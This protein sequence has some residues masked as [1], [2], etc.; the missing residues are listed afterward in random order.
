MVRQKPQAF[1][2]SYINRFMRAYS[3]MPLRFKTKIVSYQKSAEQLFQINKVNF[4]SMLL[5][6]ML[7]VIKMYRTMSK[8][9]DK[10][11]Y[12]HKSVFLMSHA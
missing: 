9:S 12:S 5:F 4:L 11:S 7:T 1:K 2:T 3:F 8:L 6:S 10:L